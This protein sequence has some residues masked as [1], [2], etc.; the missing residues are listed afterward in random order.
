MLVMLLHGKTL[1]EREERI[2]ESSEH[3]ER[4]GI[5]YENAQEH[6]GVLRREVES[7][8]LEQGALAVEASQLRDK[9]SARSESVALADDLARR[10]AKTIAELK[11][12]K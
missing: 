9:I 5:L 11:R 2:R 3:A 4:A 8:E 10:Q 7:V 1:Q 6:L 12:K